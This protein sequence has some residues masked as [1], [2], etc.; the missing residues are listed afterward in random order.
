M[1]FGI[2]DERKMREMIYF[3]VVKKCLACSGKMNDNRSSKIDERDDKR[4]HLMLD[5]NSYYL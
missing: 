4:K 2:T 1:M 3:D 5:N